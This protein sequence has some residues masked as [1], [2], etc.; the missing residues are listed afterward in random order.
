MAIFPAARLN[1]LT[2]TALESARA[3]L[4]E[5][6]TPQTVNRYM[7]FLRRVL[8]KAVRDGKLASNPVS[9]IKMFREPA[10]KTRFLSPE[11]E[12]TLCGKIGASYAG[13]VRLAI[14][15]GMRQ[16]EQ[17]SLRWEHVDLERGVLTLPTTKAGRVQY[18]RLNEEAKRLIQGSSLATSRSGCFPAKTPIPMRTLATS[19]GGYTSPRSR[20]AAWKEYL[21][22]ACAIPSPVG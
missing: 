12:G 5:G 7:G 22:T 11:E 3:H 16:M 1:A 8:N 14:L 18:V 20:S 10:G 6:R 17:F 13:W 2:P 4:S 9:R 15:T 21:G 19:I